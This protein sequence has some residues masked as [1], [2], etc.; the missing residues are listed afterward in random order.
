M[1][2]I[3]Q[4]SCLLALLIAGCGG[5]GSDTPAPATSSFPFAGSWNI[6]FTGTDT[7]SCGNVN[8]SAEGIV[9]GTCSSSSLGDFTVS[10]SVD[11][12]GVAEFGGG[13]IVLN[14]DPNS[15]ILFVMSRSF[16]GQFNSHGAGSGTWSKSGV[17]SGTWSAGRI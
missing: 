15:L 10:G 6:S 1:I 7:G 12:Q 2:K 13:E 3:K 4:F 11:V 5:G 8:I 14:P 17:K 16:S 9:S